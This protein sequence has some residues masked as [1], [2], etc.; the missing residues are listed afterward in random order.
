MKKEEDKTIVTTTIKNISTDIKNSVLKPL[1]IRRTRTDIESF[2]MYK[3]D[4]EKF[5]KIEKTN[6]LDYEL[7]NLTDDFVKTISYLEINLKYHRFRVLNNLNQKGKDKYKTNHPTISD[8]IFNDNDLSTLA[9]YSFIKRFESSFGAFKKSL[10]N[11]IVSLEQFIKDLENDKLYIGDKSNQILKRKD[12]NK[13]YIYENN[14]IYYIK[15]NKKDDTQEKVYLKGAVLQKSDFENIHIFQDGLN[16]DLE[17]L[18]V[19]KDIWD[20]HIKDPKY[21]KFLDYLMNQ[22]N[23][24]IVIFTEYTDTLDYLEKKFPAILRAKTLFITSQNRDSFQDKI[25]KF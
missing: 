4:I 13:K 7:G 21:D 17:Y 11:A 20:K 12:S 16:K 10:N 6:S 15:I 2:D 23:K 8:N 24:K 14:K 9:K 1:L 3:N 18:Q 22:P 5:P 19:L 25:S